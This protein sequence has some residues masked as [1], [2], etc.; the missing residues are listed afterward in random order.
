MFL[1]S[2]ITVLFVSLLAGCSSY[3]LSKP[4]HDD[5]LILA[6]PVALAK[7][8]PCKHGHQDGIKAC[9]EGKAAELE[10]LKKSIEK[11]Q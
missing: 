4:T 9:K 5:H 3:E 11:Y 10:Q 8:D 1:R 7:N 6:F 2:I